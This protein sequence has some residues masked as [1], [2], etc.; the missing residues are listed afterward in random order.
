MHD[1][2]VLVN[3]TCMMSV[4]CGN[5]QVDVAPCQRLH[6]TT[7]CAKQCAACHLMHAERT[8]AH[9]E[10]KSRQLLSDAFEHQVDLSNGANYHAKGYKQHV[11][12]IG[13]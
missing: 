10:Q 7:G 12:C 11:G 13:L 4:S 3:M 2:S 1:V 5:M 6:A 8:L 9:L